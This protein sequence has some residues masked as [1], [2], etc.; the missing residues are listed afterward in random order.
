MKTTAT[1]NGD[2]YEVTAPK[3]GADRA[4]RDLCRANG[5]DW[6]MAEILVVNFPE[7]GRGLH[8][9]AGFHTL[10]AIG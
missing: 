2:R 7:R 9:N 10:G 3:G 8:K 5:I 1:I 6:R 4:L